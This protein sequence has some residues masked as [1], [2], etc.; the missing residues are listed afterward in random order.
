MD[1]ISPG[2]SVHGILE[3]P[4]STGFSR[5]EYWNALPYPPAGNLPDP[6]IELLS[7]KSPALVGGFLTTSTTWE[8]HMALSLATFT[9]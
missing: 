4:L 1:C 9:I 2:F 7:L 8:A 3:C 6:G 5:Q